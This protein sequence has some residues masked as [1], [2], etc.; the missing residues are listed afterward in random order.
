MKLLQQDSDLAS[1]LRA[2]TVVDHQHPLVAATAARLGSGGT[3]DDP[4]RYARAAFEHVRDAIPHSMDT[5]DPRVTCTASE[6]LEARTGICYAKSHALA[7]LLRHRGIPTALCYQQLGVLH[8]LVAIRL[9]GHDWARLDPR[10]NK[11]GVDAR[12]SLTDERLAFVPDPAEGERDDPVLYA[13]PP[14]A[15]VAALRGSADLTELSLN[16]PTQL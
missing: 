9:P 3:S 11:D 7:A 13:I 1:Y 14:A 15:I 8:G 2:D 10:G 16:L 4:V 6:V 12:F 5:G